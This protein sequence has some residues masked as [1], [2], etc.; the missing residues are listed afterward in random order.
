M[1]ALVA[2][3]AS[4]IVREALRAAGWDAI[5]CDLQPTRRPGPHILGDVTPYLA[6]AWDLVIAH[7]PCTH[8]AVSGARWFPGKRADG[9]Q[10][11]AIDFFMRCIRANAPRVAVEHPVSI[12]STYH[13]PPTQIIQPWQFGHGE[14]K[15]T[16]LWL[17]GLPPL[18]P[19]CIVPG[20][21]ARVW[22]LPP[23]PDRADLRS[24]TLPGIA[25]AM[26]TQWSMS[27]K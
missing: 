22:R 6:R 12:L 17:K 1:T 24:A 21:D 15:A 5:S 9:R 3:E 14:V 25:A 13:G 18:V 4:G 11:R 27:L 2:C 19:T 8:T 7:P 20:R 26:A 23:S 10:Q 16:C